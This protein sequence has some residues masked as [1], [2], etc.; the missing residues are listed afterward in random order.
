[1]IGLD[2]IVE[3]SSWIAMLPGKRRFVINF[4]LFRLQLI[5]SDP[6]NTQHNQKPVKSSLNLALIRKHPETAPNSYKRK[7]Q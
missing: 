6:L 4:S 2:L 3:A 1:M 5:S 7:T